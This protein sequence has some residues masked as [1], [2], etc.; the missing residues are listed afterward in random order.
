MKGSSVVQFIFLVAFL[1]GT[2]VAWACSSFQMT[3]DGQTLVAH[4]FD[5]DSGIGLIVVN[6]RGVAKQGLVNPGPVLAE[7]TSLYG[8]VT[9]NHYGREMPQT[10]MNEAGLMITQG[11]LDE[12]QYPDA[13]DRPVVNELQWMQYVLDNYATVGEVIASVDDI[14]I[15]P[16]YGMEHYF[17]CDSEGTCA[18]F[19]FLAGQLNVFTGDSLPYSSMTNDTYANSTDYVEQFKPF[20]GTE[21]LPETTSSLDRFTRASALSTST[22]TGD[23]PDVAYDILDNI[24]QGEATRWSI[25]Y[26]PDQGRVYFKPGTSSAIRFF[27]L[28]DFDW[29][30][31]AEVL[32]LDIQSDLSGDVTEQFVPYTRQANYDLIS[33]TLG[34]IFPKGQEALIDV[35]A[36][37]PEMLPCTLESD[38]D[39]DVDADADADADAEIEADADDVDADPD[40]QFH[41]SGGS[42]GGCSASGRS[43]QVEAAILILFGLCAIFWHVRRR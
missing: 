25:V 8:S 6:K 26:Q 43:T 35:L 14:R 22:T 24:A 34:A 42:S 21:P 4:N 16:F 1:F 11:W 23:M 9:F 33:I 36:D 40:Q 39:A 27:D 17:V 38:G 29:D 37:F 12:C 13:D 31:T 19:E 15:V 41:S 18:V 10:G 32:V 5:W 7:W 30:C 20:G 3:V 2:E 28:G